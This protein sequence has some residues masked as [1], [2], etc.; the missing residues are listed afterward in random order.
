MTAAVAKRQ[1]LAFNVTLIQGEGVTALV[2]TSLPDHDTLMSQDMGKKHYLLRFGGMGYDHVMRPIVPRLKDSF[3]AGGREHGDA[4]DALFCLGLRNTFLFGL[5]PLDP[6]SARFVGEAFTLRYIPAREDLD[7]L[8]PS[9]IRPIP[10]GSRSSRW[11]GPGSRDGLPRQRQGGK[12]RSHP[13]D[14]AA[15]ARSGGTGHRRLGAGLARL[16]V[17][18][19]HLAAQIAR[20]AAEQEDLERFILGQVQAGAAL[21]G[22][23]PPNEGTL[24]TYRAARDAGHHGGPDARPRPAAHNTES[25]QPDHDGGGSA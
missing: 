5:R 21:P 23:Y 15:A 11:A 2:N 16:V 25:D 13:D 7:V 17:I 22:T 24:A 20:P 1:P 8:E 18:P 12:C 9:R 3:G 6:D 10:S 14:P 19:R 4:A